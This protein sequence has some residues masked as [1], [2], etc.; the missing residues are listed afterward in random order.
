MPTRQF[1]LFYKFLGGTLYYTDD[2]RETFCKRMI[3]DFIGYSSINMEYVPILKKLS[4]ILD[5]DKLKKYGYGKNPNDGLKRLASKTG[6]S[7]LNPY[8]HVIRS[9][10]LMLTIGMVPGQKGKKQVEEIL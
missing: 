6:S 2:S 4:F 10:D 9:T 5:D 1:T 8:V 7:K 3:G